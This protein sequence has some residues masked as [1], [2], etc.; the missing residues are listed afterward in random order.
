MNLY[1]LV[2]AIPALGMQ[3]PEIIPTQLLDKLLVLVQLLEGLHVHAG[4]AIGLGLVKMLLISKDAHGELGARD[5]PQPGDK[6]NNQCMN[7]ARPL[8]HQRGISPK[9]FYKTN[10][11]RAMEAQTITLNKIDPETYD[12]TI[13]NRENFLEIPTIQGVQ[14]TKF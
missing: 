10:P 3:K 7:S 11:S 5:V 4:D 1:H 12:Q 13:L 2:H 9:K 8:T 14:C 6:E